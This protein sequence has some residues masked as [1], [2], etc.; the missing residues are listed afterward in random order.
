MLRRESERSLDIA[1]GL[2]AATLAIC[3]IGTV[4]WT[5]YNIRLARKAPRR[6]SNREVL[7]HWERDTLGRRL[8]LP[9]EE[10]ACRAPEVRVVLK[11]GAK[12]Y[13]VVDPEEL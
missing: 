5:R 7:I 3:L 13:I 2:V 9:P 1:F 6:N 8:V 11:D 4:A 12:A 10:I